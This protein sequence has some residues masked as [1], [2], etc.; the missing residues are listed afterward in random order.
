MSPSPQ[1]SDMIA[2]ATKSRTRPSLSLFDDEDEAEAGPS[3]PRIRRR[4]SSSSNS[5][6]SANSAIDVET[7]LQLGS[8]ANSSFGVS[9]HNS[10][11]VDNH[12]SVEEDPSQFQSTPHLHL[13][14]PEPSPP[15]PSPPRVRR[16]SR[17]RS[18]TPLPALPPSVN[19]RRSR[20]NSASKSK[21]NSLAESKPNSRQRTP[22]RSRASSAEPSQRSKSKRQNAKLLAIPEPPIGTSFSLS[23]P[24]SSNPD[25]FPISYSPE[26]I[27]EDEE[28]QESRNFIQHPILGEVQVLGTRTGSF[29]LKGSSPPVA[30]TSQEVD[31]LADDTTSEASYSAL[32]DPDYGYRYSQ[33]ALQT[34]APY[35][36]PSQSQ[37]Q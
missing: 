30:I 21:P 24:S 23:L 34:Q 6:A 31:E 22:A 20:A 3:V 29:Q 14:Y 35:H 15:P 25:W 1:L 12:V 10:Q 19:G 26:C 36:S 32:L 27:H 17:A 9:A 11:S 7:Q 28:S 5:H 4:P 8:P 37:S 13:N 18:K 33:F 2:D 16:S